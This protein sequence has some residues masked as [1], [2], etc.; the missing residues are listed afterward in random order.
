MEKYITEYI[1]RRR[2]LKEEDQC[3][4][5]GKYNITFYYDPYLDQTTGKE[6][7]LLLID[8][9]DGDSHI[10]KRSLYVEN[11]RE[12][13]YAEMWNGLHR[14]NVVESLM[15]GTKNNEKIWFRDNAYAPSVGFTYG[16][17]RR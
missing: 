11:S 16:K 7:Y 9:F 13:D 5:T 6:Y 8:E 17:I 15:L 4:F 3:F 10:K 12:D 14:V 2:K 1:P